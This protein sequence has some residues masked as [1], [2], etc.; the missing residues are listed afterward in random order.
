MSRSLTS[1]EVNHLRRLIGWIRSG[2]P[3]DPDDLM[4]T[5][6]RIAPSLDHPPSEFAQN[7]LLRMHRESEAVPKYIRAA[8][9]ALEKTIKE[10]E[11]DIVD[12]KAE[13]NRLE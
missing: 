13:K 8:I 1:A 6:R 4:E 12:A 9:K 10:S 2:I 5:V 7:A 11:G 3:Q